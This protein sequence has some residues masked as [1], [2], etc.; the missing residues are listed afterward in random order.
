MLPS[1][2][3]VCSLVELA[4]L[5]IATPA[6]DHVADLVQGRITVDSAYRGFSLALIVATIILI[7]F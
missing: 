6:V 5:V 3:Q 2:A 7:A 4:E 1:A